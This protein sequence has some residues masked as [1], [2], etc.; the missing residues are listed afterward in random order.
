MQEHPTSDQTDQDSDPSGQ[1]TA[2]GGGTS[3]TGVYLL[4]AAVVLGVLL[5]PGVLGNALPGAYRSLFGGG[6][7]EYGQIRAYQQETSQLMERLTLTDVTPD[8]I[9]EFQA[10]RAETMRPL[11]MAYLAAREKHIARI[12]GLMQSLVLVVVGLSLLESLMGKNA[13]RAAGG[14]SS[15]GSP[16]RG[17]AAARF[18]CLATWVVLA[19]AQPAVL[20]DVSIITTALVLVVAIVVGLVPMRSGQAKSA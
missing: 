18:G 20:R 1:A 17:L 12:S 10:G 5:G 11:Q 13:G 4:V 2:P 15:G 8:A 9:A 19:A 16:L 3:T 14:G 7:Q 6:S